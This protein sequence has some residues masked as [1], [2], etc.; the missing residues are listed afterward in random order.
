MRGGGEDKNAQEK[1]QVQDVLGTF[2]RC[3]LSFP[4]CLWPGETDIKI[5]KGRT[6]LGFLCLWSGGENAL[7]GGGFVEGPEASQKGVLLAFLYRFM[8]FNRK[9]AFMIYNMQSVT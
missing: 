6:Y 1:W 8:A 9:A 4:K 3:L 5:R 7:Q 2:P